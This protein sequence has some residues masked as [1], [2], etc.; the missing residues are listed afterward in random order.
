MFCLLQL[1]SEWVFDVSIK[2]MTNEFS[3]ASPLDLWQNK[4][5]NNTQFICFSITL[6]LSPGTY[7]H[8]IH[9]LS[10]LKI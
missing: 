3:V 2:N 5:L 4:T 7:V 8:E 10:S 6:S 9:T 1:Q